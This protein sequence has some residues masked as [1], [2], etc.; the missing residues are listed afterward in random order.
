[1]LRAP[2]IDLVLALAAFV[3][4]L[5]DPLLLHKITELTPVMGVLAFLTAVPLAARRRFPLGVLAIEVPL[6]MACLAVFH[7][8]RAAVG[9]TMLLVFTVGLEGGRARSLVVGALMALIVTAAVFITG[10]RSGLSDVIAYSSLVLGALL[11]GEALRARQA[12]QPRRRP[13]RAK[14]RHSTPSTPN[15]SLWPTSS[16][17]SSGTPWWPST[18]GPQPPRAVSTKAVAPTGPPRWMR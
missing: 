13:A 12:L 8:N 18:C 4:L 10:Q 1:L 17:T 6:L 11:A 14:P 9:I 2:D 7:P 16:T 5:V 3:A 15:A